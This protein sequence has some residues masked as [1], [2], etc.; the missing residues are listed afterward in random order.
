MHVGAGNAADHVVG[1]DLAGRWLIE[2]GRIAHH[3]FDQMVQNGERDVD[4]QQAGDR[5]VDAAIVPQR[6]G[7]HDPQPTADDSSAHHREL[8]GNRR[9]RRQRERGARRGQGSDQQRAFAAD[10]DEAELCRQRAA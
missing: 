9:H 10:D 2:T 7:E 1:A 6:A 5:F 3:A 8:H 4:Q